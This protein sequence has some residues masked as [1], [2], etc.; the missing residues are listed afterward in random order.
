MWFYVYLRN[1]SD[2]S[3]ELCTSLKNG[4]K[5]S[6]KWAV[7]QLVKYEYFW[8]TISLR[9]ILTEVSVHAATYNCY[10][11]VTRV[12]EEYSF[13]AQLLAW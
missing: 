9:L 4:S 7:P 6:W 12:H 5:V 13:T 1:E 3:L 8:G 2:G 10:T 11:Y